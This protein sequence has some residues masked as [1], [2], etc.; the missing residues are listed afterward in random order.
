VRRLSARWLPLSLGEG[1]KP[2]LEAL[3]RRLQ[4]V[5]AFGDLLQFPRQLQIVKVQ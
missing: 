1:T 2:G 3:R 4:A 5:C